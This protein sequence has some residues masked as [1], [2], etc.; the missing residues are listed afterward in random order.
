[1]KMGIVST[2][3]RMGD[4]TKG[5]YRMLTRMDSNGIYHGD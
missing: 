1:M 5:S 2:N 4:D 3:T